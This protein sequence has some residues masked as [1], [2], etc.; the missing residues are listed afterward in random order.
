MNF[1]RIISSPRIAVKQAVITRYRVH[2]EISKLPKTTLT[3]IRVNY[4]FLPRV[5]IVRKTT[6]LLLPIR[7]GCRH[8]F[9]SS[10]ARNLPVTDVFFNRDIFPLV[11][12]AGVV[13]FPIYFFDYSSRYASR[14]LYFSSHVD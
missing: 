13:F 14:P 8:S 3:D 11:T 10:D 12:Q 1:T 4:I 6:N 5:I 7:F 9:R 2:T